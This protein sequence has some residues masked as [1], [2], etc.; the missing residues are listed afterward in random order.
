M[1]NPNPPNRSETWPLIKTTIGEYGQQLPI[2]FRESGSYNRH[3]ALRAFR[4]AEEEVIGEIRAKAKG[5]T[6]GRL[7]AEILGVLI[8]EVGPY[9]FGSMKTLDK[10]SILNGMHYGDV[11][12]MYL[13][14]RLEAIGPEVP[15]VLDCPLC[16]T[17][18]R[19]VGDMNDLDV[20]VLDEEA[21]EEELRVIG[22]ELKHGMTIRGEAR[23]RISIG[24]MRWAALDTRR[25]S[26]SS[27]LND[28]VREI[29]VIRS[30]IDG[31]EGVEG[32]LVLSDTEI[33]TISKYD[34]EQLHAV[35]ND[36]MAGPILI[37]EHVC[38]GC[39]ETLYQVMDWTYDSFFRS[40]RFAAGKN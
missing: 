37:I 3:F 31:A 29:T 36:K 5:I 8:K 30:S 21:G 24:P 18:N 25:L 12:Y 4:F 40:S 38:E 6:L 2:G 9:D 22:H 20:T 23:H 39:G 26:G 27:V 28:A 16:R 34:K 14:A 32:S 35:I 15:F 17:R 33:R 1:E 19:G 10:V 13:W 11:M 7:V